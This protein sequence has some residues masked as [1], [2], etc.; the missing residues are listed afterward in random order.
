MAVTDEDTGEILTKPRMLAGFTLQEVGGPPID[1]RPD[2][3]GL[4]SDGRFLDFS[5]SKN[6]LGQAGNF[7]NREQ[8]RLHSVSVTDD[9]ERVYVA[10]TTAGFYVIDSEGV[11]RGRNAQLAAGQAGCNQRSTIASVNGVIDAA[12]LPLIANDCLHMVVNNDPGL[13]AFLASNASPEAKGAS[14][15]RAADTLALRRLSPGERVTDGHAQRGVRSQSA[16]A[17]PRQHERTSSLRVVERRE[18]RVPAQLR[19]DGL[20]RIRDDADHG[21]RLCDSRQPGRGVPH[22]SDDRAERSTASPHTATESQPDDLQEPGVHHV[23]RGLRVIDISNPFTPR[24]VGHALTVPQGVARTYP[25]FKDGLIYWV[26][27]DTGLHVARYTGPRADE[28]PG[29]GTGT[30]EG[31]ATS[32]TGNRWTA[33]LLA[34]SLCLLVGLFVRA[35]Q[36]GSPSS[37]DLATAF[38]CPMHPDYTLDIA[39]SC[40]RCGMALVRGAPFDVRDYGL[41]LTTEPAVVRAGQPARWRFRVSHPGTGERIL[42]FETVH[43]RQYHLFVISHDMTQFQHIHPELQ[44]DGT[45][46]IDVTLPKAGYYKVL[47]DFLP[48]GGASQLI[49]RPIVTAGYAGDL[50][51]DAA[52]LT[53]DTNS[54]QTV[55]DLTATVSYDP[56][57]SLPGST[58]ICSSP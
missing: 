5:D 49:A 30:Y 36:G 32:R 46:V 37:A 1:E 33:I 12:K 29:P 44:P 2:A 55:D 35:Q 57:P 39:G 25:I 16:G 15:P 31:N 22:A 21:R 11:A 3:T 8:N 52:R 34:L 24:E 19:A 42:K 17:R 41:E 26:D 14:L 38:V 51:G 9:G 50:A 43:E 10:G 56:R 45:W 4:F 7:Q 40:P 23:V 48:A 58:V 54:R 27:N 28:L 18:R 53:P 13:K 6:A 47:S 20:G